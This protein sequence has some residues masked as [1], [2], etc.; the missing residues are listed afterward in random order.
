MAATWKLEANKAVIFE[1][2]VDKSLNLLSPF[3][4]KIPT[5]SGL[6]DHEVR[7][8]TSPFDS[9]KP[10][11]HGRWQYQAQIEVKR[12]KTATEEQAVTE[13]LKPKTVRDFVF[14]L[15]QNIKKLG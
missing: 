3:L 6:I 5:P 15:G 4:L 13:L 12:Y 2:F 1:A 14:E 10:L 9:Y 11:E 8:K 7:F